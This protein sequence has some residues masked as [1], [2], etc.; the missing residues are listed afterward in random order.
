MIAPPAMNN[1][2]KG[3]LKKCKT[4]AMAAS[5]S[6]QSAVNRIRA[7]R[8]LTLV[9]PFVFNLT[10]YLMEALSVEPLLWKAASL[11]ASSI[12]R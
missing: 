11:V 12:S 9:K 7:V 2:E 5:C 3:N 6:A 4:P 10:F 8:S 1:P